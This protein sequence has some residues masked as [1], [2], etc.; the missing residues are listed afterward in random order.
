MLWPPALVIGLLKWETLGVFSVTGWLLLFAAWG[1][2][3]LQTALPA[4]W[5]LAVAALDVVAARTTADD[6]AF[7]YHA[8]SVVPA[9][10]LMG[11]GFA[12]LRDESA[13]RVLGFA[14]GWVR[15]TGAGILA[16]G[17]LATHVSGIVYLTRAGDRRDDLRAM[18]ECGL[19]FLPFIPA[20][21]A[22]VARGGEVHDD[23]GFPVA[24]NASMLFAWLDRRGFTY[25]DEELSVA[26]LEGLARRGG[27]YWIADR[28]EMNPD[29]ERE[30]AARFRRL[31][32]CPQ[33]YDL[34]D[35]ATGPGGEAGAGETR[36]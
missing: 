13:G 30:A 8:V 16:A 21:G 18:R 2:P 12:A 15:R 23:H 3:R 34:Y 26:H 24:H 9:G 22:I 5:L 11:A 4:F 20:D 32:T 29:R 10:L 19:A 25:G 7:Y 35:L 31:A 1:A 14:S 6:W 36:P 27:R 17:V 28:T 33:G